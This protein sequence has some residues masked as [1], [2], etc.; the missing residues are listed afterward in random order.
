[1]DGKVILV[2]EKDEKIGLADKM[3]A[4]T[5]GLL[6]RAFSVFVLNN[7]NEMLIHKRALSKYH[8]GG[9]WTN[10]CCSHPKDGETTLAAAHRRLKEELGIDCEIKELFTHL[11]KLEVDN[12]LTEHEYDHVYIGKFSN[13]IQ[14]NPEEVAEYKYIPIND[15]LKWIEKEPTIFTAWFRALLPIFLHHLPHSSASA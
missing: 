7:K 10:A 6:H 3:Q 2:N 8:S 4:H 13:E 5:F 1:M 12:K 14:A 11:Y 9:L 15:L